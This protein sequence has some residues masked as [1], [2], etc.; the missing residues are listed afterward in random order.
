M[1]PLVMALLLVAALGV[2]GVSIRGRWKLLHLSGER[3]HI[4]RIGERFRLT[5]KYALGQKRLT[6]YKFA[7]LAHKAIF[8]GFLML[9]LRTLILFARGFTG[10]PKFGYWIFDSGDLLGN[11]YGLIKDIYIVL[12]ITGVVVFLHYRLVIKPK[13][14]TLNGEGV[15][16]LA[17]ILVMLLAD[18][19]YEGAGLVL[20]SRDAAGLHFSIWE[21]LG[22]L[23]IPFL[24]SAPDGTLV[25]LYHLG[26]WTHVTLVLI[27]LNLLPH[28][29]HFHI[30]TAIPNI[31]M[32]ELEPAGKLKPI[33]DIEGRI[34]REE[35]LGIRRIDQFSFNAILD[36]YSCTECGRCTDQCPA[37]RTGKLLSPKQLTIDLRDHL[38]ANQSALRKANGDKPAAMDDLVPA[39][40]DT[41]ALWACTT[42]GACEQE[43]PLHISFVDKIVDLRRYLVQEKGECS[44]TLQE[45]F[46]SME[47]TGS[48]YG[49]G[50]D[51]RMNWAAGLD[52]PLRNETDDIDILFWVGCAPATDERAKSIARAMARL[53]NLAG[54][55]WAV[56]GPEESCTGDVAR[57]A[58]NEYLFQAMAE[59]NIETLNG[60]HTKKILTVCP[61]CFNTLQHEYPDFGG[62]YE[63][64]HH[65]EYLAKLMSEGKLTPTHEVNTTI[66]YHD[67]CYLGRLNGIYDS[68]RKILASIPGVTLVEATASRDRGMCCGAGGGQMFK[69]D[70]PGDE[71]IN[72]ARADQLLETGADTISSACPFCMRMLTDALNTKQHIDIAQLDIAEVLLKSVT[73][74]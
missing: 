12:V 21:P 74:A 11:F 68:P 48:P 33:E 31:F 67:S 43:C 71:R 20:A 38:Y 40:I 47:A 4:D 14:M 34:D 56:L 29:K 41:E 17:I 70:E 51:E 32:Q 15:L 23:L 5:L 57:R 24:E 9:L 66:V 58:G 1:N 61:H 60:Y 42:C 2:F 45:T 39:V 7:G 55:K 27:F 18:V 65:T 37:A 3:P 62:K 35:T 28:T 36:F 64:I 26:F 52:V 22:S 50:S 69:E 6:R 44:S 10:D 46:S 72:F 63:V 73:G 53:L 54:L 49:V 25:F 13:R 30:I 8:F 59:A 19:L 16:I